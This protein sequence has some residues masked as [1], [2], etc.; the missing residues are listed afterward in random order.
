MYLTEKFCKVTKM[1]QITGNVISDTCCIMSTGCLEMPKKP[2]CFPTPQFARL[3][4]LPKFNPKHCGKVNCTTSKPGTAGPVFV[5]LL[6]CK[7]RATPSTNWNGSSSPAVGTAPQD[8]PP[9]IRTLKNTHVDDI[10][11]TVNTGNRFKLF[12]RFVTI[13]YFFR[14][15]SVIK[16]LRV[17]LILGKSSQAVYL[18]Y[19][20][21]LAVSTITF[22]AP[23]AMAYKYNPSTWYQTC[24]KS[25]IN[26]SVDVTLIWSC[27]FPHIHRESPAMC[28]LCAFPF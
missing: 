28:F 8:Y 9:N 23:K 19:E 26:I 1:S 10:S 22:S 13:S 17:F 14:I 18:L 7:G 15:A 4:E 21:N 27:L 16:S 5:W 20:Y 3:T 12:Q 11:S 25:K 24:I 2:L 6:Q